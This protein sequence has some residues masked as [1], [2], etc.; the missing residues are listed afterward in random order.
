[1]FD[2]QKHL[3]DSIF[4]EESQ[5]AMWID[6]RGVHRAPEPR[7]QDRAPSV[8]VRLPRRNSFLDHKNGLDGHKLKA[9]VKPDPLD[10]VE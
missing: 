3:P 2:A 1:M 7:A 10:S 9:N 8:R 6:C 4:S 5:T